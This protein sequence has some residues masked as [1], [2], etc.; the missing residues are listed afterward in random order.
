V[1]LAACASN[2]AE[3]DAVPGAI[4]V[5]LISAAG[6]G[7]TYALPQHS[8]LSLLNESSTQIPSY[9]VSLD[10]DTDVVTFAAGVGNYQA[11]IYNTD[12]DFTTNWPL[13]HTVAGATSVVDAALI[14]P[15]PMSVAVES[16]QTTP[17]V[18]QFAILSSGTITF[19]HG[20]VAVAI[21][22]TK[23]TANGFSAGIQ[24]SGDVAGTPTFTGPFAAELGAVMPGAGS[25]GLQLS[26][27]A[28]LIGSFQEAGGSMDA[29]GSALSVC[30]PLEV[31]A[32]SGSGNAGFADLIAESG[33]GTS[34]T[35][36]FGPA[37][38]CIVDDGATNQ[39]RI[40][41][42][43]EGLAETATFTAIFADQP[44]VFWNVIATTLPTRIYDAQAGTLNLDA[45]AGTSAVPM[46]L[47]NRIGSDPLDLWYIGIVQGQMNFSFVG[48]P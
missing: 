25:T 11:E 45:L 32:S 42:S 43:R 24:G 39:L 26:V 38:M 31:V 41:M 44:V 21:D 46:R 19:D 36:L 30:A 12:N 4:S 35:F 20:T 6:D 18:F 13:T 29:E 1:T 23:Q 8:R 10:G 5:A 47:F 7:T 37:T 3:D 27:A 34:P 15:Q 48:Q 22:V 9:D 2:K 40:R 17:V 14:T 16:G 28:N 33:H